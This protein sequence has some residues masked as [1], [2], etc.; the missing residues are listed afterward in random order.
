MVTKQVVAEDPK[1]VRYTPPIETVERV[2]DGDTVVLHLDLGFDI[3]YR[4]TVRLNGIDTPEMHSYTAT[5]AQVAQSWV[6]AWFAAQKQPIYLK[7]TKWDKYGGRV[8]GDVLTQ[9][10]RSLV[11][12][13]LKSKIGRPYKGEAKRPWTQEELTDVISA[14]VP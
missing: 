14:K 5:A 8:L 3:T 1:A 12:E 11:E 9:D 6:A 2:K 4:A 10:G 7:S 13:M